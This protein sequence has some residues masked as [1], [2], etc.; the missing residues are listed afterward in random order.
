MISDAE[1]QGVVRQLGYVP[2]TDLSGLYRMAEAFLCVSR[3]EGFGFPALEAMACGT[4]VVSSLAGAM[5]QT[6][7]NAAVSVNVEDVSSV[8]D[9]LAAVL[10]DASLR[11]KMSRAGLRQSR[12][13]RWEN[14]LDDLLDTYQAACVQR[15]GRT[16][17][18]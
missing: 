4:P 13:F 15:R 11:Y 6:L 14:T 2:R 17:S 9:A 10:S 7:G 1:A 16:R 8:A 18:R 12:R 5:S 3:H